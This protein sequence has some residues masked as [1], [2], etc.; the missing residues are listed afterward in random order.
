MDD[1]KITV[2]IEF[3]FNIECNSIH[4]IWHMYDTLMIPRDTLVGMVQYTVSFIIS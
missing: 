2:I 1:D 4:L 3:S